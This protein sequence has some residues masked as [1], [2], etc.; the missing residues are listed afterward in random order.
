[1]DRETG[2]D[3]KV[4]LVVYNLLVTVLNWKTEKNTR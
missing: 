4:I 2:L 1:M 3:T